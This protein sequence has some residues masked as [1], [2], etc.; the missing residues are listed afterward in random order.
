MFRLQRKP[1][2]QKGATFLR[3]LAMSFEFEEPVGKIGNI[4]QEAE[5]T[6]IWTRFAEGLLMA[7]DPTLKRALDTAWMLYLSKA[8]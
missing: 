1:I 2:R 4:G 5:L 6:P 8:R 3:F 7:E